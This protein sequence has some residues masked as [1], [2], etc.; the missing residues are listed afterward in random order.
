MDLISSVCLIMYFYLLFTP[1]FYVGISTFFGLGSKK[2]RIFCTSEALAK[3]KSCAWELNVGTPS[4]SIVPVLP[5][6]LID[7]LHSPVSG[8][9]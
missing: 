4:K 2:E 9:Q 3:N 1:Q 6:C 5:L 7:V 8:F